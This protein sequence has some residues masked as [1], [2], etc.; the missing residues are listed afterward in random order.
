MIQPDALKK[1]EP[2][3]WSPGLGTDV[4]EMFCAAA[5]GDLE[6]LKRLLDKDAALV[7]GQYA[8]L[9]PLYFAVREN[10][11]E[12]AA[13]LLS[14]GADPLCFAVNDSLLQLAQDRAYA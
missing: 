6:T 11:V 4:W 1:A 7:H 2:L 5:S 10:Q 8:Y 13:F 14:H 12:A 3:L 9:T